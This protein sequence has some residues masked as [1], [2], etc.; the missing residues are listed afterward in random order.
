M[1]KKVLTGTMVAVLMSPLLTTVVD[2]SHAEP[3]ITTQQAIAMYKEKYAAYTKDE[4]VKVSQ[5]RNKYIGIKGSL[6][7]QIVERAIWYMENGYTV[8]GHGRKMYQQTGVV[9]CSNFTSL[10]FADFGYD[11][12]TAVREYP[13]VG[14]RITGISAKKVGNYWTI[15]GMDKLKPGDLLTW[16]RIDSTTGQKVAGHTAIYMGELNGQPA[17]IGTQSGNPTAVGIANDFRFW[18]GSNF[19]T[20]QRVLPSNAWTKGVTIAGHQAKAPIIPTNPILPPQNKVVVPP[21]T[22]GSQVNP[23]VSQNQ[24]TGQ[25]YVVTRTGWVTYRDRP[26]SSGSA[27]GRLELGQFA[28]LKRQYNNYWYEIAINGRTAYITTNPE[29]TKVVIK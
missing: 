14:Q 2:A 8:Y 16:W 29:Y 18:W 20:A 7:D 12:P 17:V 5:Y 25:K 9:D 23:D 10:V 19:F 1:L 22:G 27:I 15:E 6:A 21:S 4:L 28:L 24:P 3:T 26:S 11:I 13:T